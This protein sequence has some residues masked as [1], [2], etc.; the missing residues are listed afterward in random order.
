MADMIIKIAFVLCCLVTIFLS[1]N[2]LIEGGFCQCANGF[3]KGLAFSIVLMYIARDHLISTGLIFLRALVI[4]F[5][6]VIGLA[7]ALY[8]FCQQTF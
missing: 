1:L 7:A 4:C 8:F 6:A 3:F 5:L 2:G